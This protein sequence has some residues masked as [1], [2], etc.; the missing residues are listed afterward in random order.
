MSAH[1]H[2]RRSKLTCTGMIVAPLRRVR[3]SYARISS[4]DQTVAHQRKQAEAAGVTIDHPRP[5]AAERDRSKSNET[6]ALIIRADA[7][8]QDEAP[9]MPSSP[10]RRMLSVTGRAQIVHSWAAPAVRRGGT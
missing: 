1:E 3:G 4:V 9:V 10:V 6:A 8:L 5:S 2:V 7:E